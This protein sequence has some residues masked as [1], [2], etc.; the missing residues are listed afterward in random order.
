[1]LA[2]PSGRRRLI[3]HPARYVVLWF[4][5]AITV[6]TVLLLLPVSTAPGRST[7]VLTAAFT[8]TSAVCVTGLAVVDTATHWS[9]FG[10]AMILLLVEFGG[11]GFMTI[12]SL[13]VMIVSRRLGLR[14]QLATNAERGALSLGD[15]RS[16]LAGLAVVT[17]VVQIGVA[18]WLAVRFHQVRDLGLGES[19]W[20]GVF[21]SVMAFNNAGFALYTDNLIGFNGDWLILVPIM[22]AIVIGG[23]GFPVI[24]DLTRTRARWRGLTLHSKLTLT[25]TA[26]L[27]V[28]GFLVLTAFE[29]RNPGTL[30]PMPVG[31]KVLNGAFASVT[32]RTAGFN[33]I[34][35]GAMEPESLLSTT[36]LMFVGAGSAG[37]SGGI[38]VGTFAVLA[39]VVWSEVRGNRDVTG[40]RRRIPGT[41]QRQAI[42]VAALAMTLVLGAAAV[43]LISAK[44]PLGDA[45]FEAVSAFGTVGLST[46]ITP[47]LPGADQ[48]ILMVLMLVGRVGPITLGAALVLRDRPAR[49]RFPEEGPLIG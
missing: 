37:T 38:K 29:W 9:P 12:A 44:V 45:V 28:V 7:G 8:A 27:L 33:S 14:R 6:G 36:A 46:G 24:V 25:A 26:A 10:Q 35:V 17:A 3:D 2:T 22:T 43:M 1:M 4:L 48:V 34:D 16:V 31:Q 18:L 39:L 21:H 41:T 15:V 42:T 49:F 20:Q 13:I 47:T 32:P 40:F 30:G 5:L 11:L 23:L 19:L